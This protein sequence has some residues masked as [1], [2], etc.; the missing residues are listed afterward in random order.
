VFPDHPQRL[1]ARINRREH[2]ALRTIKRG[3]LEAKAVNSYRDPLTDKP[4]C[5]VWIRYVAD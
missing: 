2:P 4:R 1:V 3:H 5:D